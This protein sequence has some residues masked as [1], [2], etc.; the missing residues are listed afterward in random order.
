MP[1]A[2]GAAD[3]WR[4]LI[5]IADSFGPPWGAVARDAASRLIRGF[6]RGYR[7]DVADGHPRLF[8]GLPRSLPSA[9]WSGT[10]SISKTPAGENRGALT[11]A[12]WRRAAAVRDSIAIDLAGRAPRRQARA[13][14][15][16]LRAQFEAA[17][18]RYCS[19]DS[20]PAQRQQYQISTRES[21]S[22]PSRHLAV[23]RRRVR[24]MAR[25]RGWTRNT[26]PL[27]H[28]HD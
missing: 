11:V 28:E 10:W 19:K 17:W 3:N 4:A 13:R 25:H 18:A 5:S 26:P 15:V 16:T 14:K 8:D 6:R 2:C 7:R 22:A 27:H 12:G 9:D 1:A 20:T 23:T 21:E 24:H